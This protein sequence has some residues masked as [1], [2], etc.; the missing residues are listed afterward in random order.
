MLV[1]YLKPTQVC[2]GNA[3]GNQA[4]ALSTPELGGMSLV[5]ASIGQTTFVQLTNTSSTSVT[6]ANV[7][8]GSDGALHSTIT[9]FN[10]NVNGHYAN[11]CS[12]VAS[13]VQ[14]TYTFAQPNELVEN[15]HM[16]IPKD[17]IL[18]DSQSRILVVFNNP[19]M[20]SNIRSSPQ[21]VC[22]QTNGGKQTSIQIG[23]ITNLVTVWY[24]PE[25]IL[26]VSDVCK[27]CK[28]TTEIAIDPS[29]SIH[30][31]MFPSLWC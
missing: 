4:S 8:P 24:N 11:A 13:L 20:I 18:L 9:C 14:H 26:S 27:V 3:N 16:G 28:V 29:M 1:N 30:D 15:Q 5:P 22:V 17:G 2:Q 21:E 23:D 10:C 25:S 6:R 31:E 19:R 12:S 7:V